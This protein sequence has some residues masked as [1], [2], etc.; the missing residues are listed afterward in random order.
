MAINTAHQPLMHACV[1]QSEQM[2]Q[3]PLRLP[4]IQGYR[5]TVPVDGPRREAAYCFAY[6]HSHSLNIVENVLNP[7]ARLALWYGPAT[8]LRQ[9]DSKFAEEIWYAAG[10]RAVLPAQNNQN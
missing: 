7:A 6:R 8:D 5:S 4:K 2:P 10:I 1:L 9:E 3:R